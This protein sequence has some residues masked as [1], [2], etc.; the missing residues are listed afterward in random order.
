MML[1]VF[2]VLEIHLRHQNYIHRFQETLVQYPFQAVRQSHSEN[3]FRIQFFDHHH[4]SKN[5]P[6]NCGY[7]L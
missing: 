4:F 5:Q 1:Q 3:L 2:L 6:Q 7:R